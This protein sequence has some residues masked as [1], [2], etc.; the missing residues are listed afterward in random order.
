MRTL[1]RDLKT[2]MFYGA[3]GQWTGEREDARDFGGSFEA[4]RFAGENHLSGVEVVL[5]FDRPEYDVVI[6]L[7]RAQRPP[8]DYREGPGRDVK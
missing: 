6:R 1:I 5:A 3:D 8:G 7:D 4:M 2:G